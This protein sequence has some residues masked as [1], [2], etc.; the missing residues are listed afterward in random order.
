[1]NTRLKCLIGLVL[2]ASMV[3]QG[4]AAEPFR[5][6]GGMLVFE[7]EHFSDSDKRTDPANAQ[8]SIATTR[9]G[10][11]GDGYVLTPPAPDNNGTWANGCELSYEVN[12]S[13]GGTYTVWHRRFAADSGTNSVWVGMDGVQVGNTNN[14]NADPMGVWV[15]LKLDGTV[16]VTP[17]KHVFQMRRREGGF[18]Q[19]RILMTLDPAYKPT[20]DGPAESPRG[21]PAKASE[22]NPQDK[23]TDVSRDVVLSWKAGAYA[24]KHNVYLGTSLADVNTASGAKPLGVLV[25]AG[26]DAN[27]FDPTGLEFGKTYYWRVDEVNAPTAGA[28]VFQGDVW[29]FTLEPLAYPVKNVLATASSSFDGTTGPEKT[30]DGSGLNATDAHSSV[31]NTMWLTN[32][33]PPT[34][35]QYQ[36]DGVYKLR[37]MWVWN[38]NQMIESFAGIGAKDVTVEYSTDGVN[39]TTLPGVPQ[40][41]KASGA[42][43]Y[44][45]NTTVNFA[46][47]VAKY[48]KLTIRSTWG[49]VMPQTGLSE[50]RFF[51]TPVLPRDPQPATAQKEVAPDV[52]LTW[53]S[54]RE[55]VSHNVYFGTDPNALVLAGTTTRSSYT[56]ASLNLGTTY[57]WK[58]EEVNKVE[59]PSAWTGK[60]WSF[61]TRAYTVIDDM[62]KYTDETGKAIF[63][64]W[65]DGYNVAANGSQV[66]YD[67]AP[68]AERTIVHGGKQSMPLRYDNT[69]PVNY[70][71]AELTLPA[72]QDWTRNGVNTLSVYFRGVLP[73]FVQVAQD[74]VLMNGMGTDIGGTA[75]QGRFVYKQLTGNGTIIARVD[76]LDATDGQAKACVMIRQNLQPNSVWASSLFTPGYGCYFVVRPTA[77]AASASDLA[78]ATAAQTAVRGSVWLKVERVGNQLNAYY[79]TIA[80]PTTWIPSPLKPQTVTM[81]DPVYIGLAV[82]SHSATAVAQAEFSAIAT[83][84][85]VTGN[86]QS[87]DLG[88]AQPA[89][90]TPDTFYVTVTDSTNKSV[91]VKH[92]DPLAVTTGTWQ[93]WQ[94]PLGSLTG[95]NAAK[96]KSLIVGVGDRTAPK[97][98]VGTLYLDDIA[99]GCPAQ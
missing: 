54:G 60:V 45:H 32:A 73:G 38:S 63:D 21:V 64:A 24:T 44:V 83:T 61:S 2:T 67:K 19:D 78:V 4:F 65:L 71:E 57:C 51:Y 27:T 8:W 52:T 36:F 47:A 34:W 77:G 70:S 97:H 13:T 11:V 86:W 74:H 76:R 6:V 89:G 80:A 75:D 31:A 68:F 41:A 7:A 46:G 10:F 35:I 81:T 50:V 15:W 84:G 9:A 94:I 20:G 14:N 43:T 26:Q 90:N 92:P 91:T 37:E 95:V 98:G 17:G 42:D 29:S 82:T 12:F 53:R 25:S 16:T 48:V 55:A 40:F 59:T 22:P 69:S 93:Q 3:M 85:N 28:T 49:G 72:A 33:A 56:P 99:V 30:I 58:I 39:W 18:I 23:A 87:V 62:E 66:G 5:E 88:V 79:A 1:M 96:V